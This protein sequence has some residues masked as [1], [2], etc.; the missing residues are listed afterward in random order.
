VPEEEEPGAARILR[1]QDIRSPQERAR[2]VE[3]LLDV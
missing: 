3:P 2:I 1:I